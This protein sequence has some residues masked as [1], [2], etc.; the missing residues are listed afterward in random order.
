M[1]TIDIETHN[2]FLRHFYDMVYK[3]DLI[4]DIAETHQEIGDYWKK[5]YRDMNILGEHQTEEEVW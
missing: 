2:M 4:N 1:A 5:V 3:D